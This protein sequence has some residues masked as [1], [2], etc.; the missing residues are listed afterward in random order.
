MLKSAEECSKPLRN[1][2][3]LWEIKN[4]LTSLKHKLF[5]LARALERN[6]L[7]CSI[8]KMS[9]YWN[10]LCFQNRHWTL[11]NLLE[12]LRDPNWCLT[13]MSFI[14]ALQVLLPVQLAPE[15]G[16]RSPQV[17]KYVVIREFFII[18]TVV[19]LLE[20]ILKAILIKIL[21]HNQAWTQF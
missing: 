7:N 3:E 18:D 21:T 15:I 2:E 20:Q 8:E 13:P 17:V 10:K 14:S 16:L 1:A 12:S 19:W 11:K 5:K 4:V 9:E 6:C